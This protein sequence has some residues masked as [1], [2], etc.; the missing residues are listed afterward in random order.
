M[1]EQQQGVSVP[2]VVISMHAVSRDAAFSEKPCVYCQ[3]DQPEQLASHQDDDD[4]DVYEMKLI[5][6]LPEQGAV[7]AP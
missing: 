7:R 3:L 1:N 2:F 4:L 5:P 6:F